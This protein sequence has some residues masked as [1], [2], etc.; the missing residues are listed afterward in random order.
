MPD[1]RDRSTTPEQRFEKVLAKILLAEEAGKRVDLARVVRAYPDLE[2]SLR[3]YF[4][5][6]DGFDRLA[7]QLA[8][9]ASDATAQPDLVAGSQFAGYEIVRELGRGGMGVVYL[10]R[11]QGAKR[12]VAL[13]LIRMDRL[14]HL[15][16]QQRKKWLSR[17]RTEGQATAR[18][19]DDGVVTVYEVGALNGRPYY[20]MRY[21][22][23][24]SLAEVLEKGPFPN[25]RAARLIQQVARAVQAVHDHNVKHRD[26]KPHNILVDA[27]GRPYVSD[28][29]LAQWEEASESLTHTG[30]MLGSA[31]YVS[32]EQAADAAHVTNATDIYSL[33][34]TFYAV[35]TGQPPFPGKTLGEILH[36]VKYCEPVRPRRLKPAIDRDLET[37]TLR[38]LEKDPK[39]RLVSA[40]E[41]AD[42][43]ERYL[44]GRPIRT[45]PVGPA[46]QLWRWC[47]RK[48]VLA[49]LGAAVAMLLVVIGIVAS[50][51][52]HAASKAD[53]LEQVVVGKDK[54]LDKVAKDIPIL[55]KARDDKEAQAE[56]AREESRKKG[57]L[58]AQETA[59]RAA[60]TYLDDMRKAG[61]FVEVGNFGQAVELVQKYLP[62]PGETV[63]PAWEWYLL[64]AQCRE[65]GFPVRGN[66]GQALA[67]ARE[68]GFSLR[69]HTSQVVAVAWRPDGTR[70]ASVDDQGI[71]KIWDVA[72]GKQWGRD[73]SAKGP[74]NFAL[75]WSP[76]GKRLAM[77]NQVNLQFAM[78]VQATPAPPPPGQRRAGGGGAMGRGPRSGSTQGKRSTPSAQGKVQIWDLDSGKVV[79]TLP[80]VINLSLA[81]PPKPGEVPVSTHIFLGS[82]TLSLMWS[83]SGQKLALADA[84]GKVQIWDLDRDKAPHILDAHR[85][86]VHSAAWSPDGRWLASVGGDGLVK[87]WDHTTGK[88]VFNLP[89][90]EANKFMPMTSYA[91]TWTEDTKR[92]NVVTGGEIRVVDV[93]A[94]EV[95]AP[96]KLV[97]SDPSVRQGLVAQP[98]NRSIWGP[99]A[100]LLASIQTIGGD[101]KIWDAATGQEIAAIAASGAAGAMLTAGMCAPTWDRSGQRLALGGSDGTV[102]AY[103][104]GSRQQAV[105]Q[106]II[107]TALAWSAD[108]RHIF[109]ARAWSLATD[110][111][112]M[113]QQQQMGP[114]LEALQRAASRGGLT[115]PDP[116]A[117]LQPRGPGM[118]RVADPK[119][120]PQIE[121]RDAL[122][123]NVIGTMGDA[124]HPDAL[125]ESPDGKWLASATGTGLL[126]LWP[127]AGGAPAITLERPSAGGAQAG[128]PLANRVVLAWS[129]D[130]TRLA[131][132]TSV[133]ASIRIWDPVTRKT[134]Q[135]L[136]GQWR[137]LRS[138]SWSHNGQ[139]LAAAGDDGMVRVWD[140]LHGAETWSFPYYIK[141]A[142]GGM[143]N[144]RASST[145]SWCPDGKRLAVAGE[146]EAIKVWDV[147]ARQEVTP[148]LHGHSS[149]KDIHDVICAVAWSPDGRRLAS[150]SPDGTFLLWDTATW[151]EVLTLR[152]PARSGFQPRIDPPGTGGTLAWSP[153][154]RQLGFFGGENVTIW[155]ATPEGED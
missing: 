114:A 5:N 115:A 80:T 119:P 84:D 72:K 140:V 90:R 153:N 49:G 105:R 152:R 143:A 9:T 18:I 99:G 17:F 97:S 55:T 155:D 128:A 150:T 132:S 53:E 71:L 133:E 148:A 46:E 54:A 14:A 131:Y 129:T 52:H 141:H 89:V 79:K 78:P 37:I 20:S 85:G 51:L 7:P 112:V 138:L 33:G 15:T 87:V 40:A 96:R 59:R 98:S 147:D 61:Q 32:P 21:V 149:Q 1:N 118:P 104:V 144:P 63:R 12:P 134:G 86:G 139:R 77:V 36:Q 142:S 2:A 136:Q 101:V 57:K 127:V 154:G 76:D 109:A 146:D 113:A 56:K 151:Q 93:G 24:Q 48:P 95:T 135:T 111:M 117:I 47:R 69:G 10:A 43:L 116:N 94:R 4:R 39:K 91:L 28:F 107:P 45:R 108:G 38:C 19:T 106:L 81:L 64:E 120:L 82:W 22:P 34:A 60:M 11:Q 122:T 68:P 130:S 23:G 25:R 65:A 29:G 88:E 26:L 75:A 110:P 44:E 41:V 58:A 124:V 62:A 125:A 74:G 67:V 70:L 30:E 50:R 35:L 27:N 121:I 123:G 8:S 126:Q 6:R 66:P 145:L 3:E 103:P 137:A 73:L 42:E 83:P 92:L 13:K 16:P 31:H 100:K 102:L